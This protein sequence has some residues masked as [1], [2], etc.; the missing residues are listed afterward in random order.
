[1]SFLGENNLLPDSQFI[2]RKNRSTEDAI[3]LAINPWL[4]AKH[5]RRITGIV[6]VDMS[7]AFDRVRHNLLIS[8]LAAIGV[9]E[10]VRSWLCSYLSDRRQRV[11]VGDNHSDHARCSRGVPQGSVLGPLLFVIYISKRVQCL[12]AEVS[13]MEYADD[14]MLECTHLSPSTICRSLSTAVTGLGTWFEDRGL[15]PVG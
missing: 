6:F 13:N 5:Q 12:P 11:R 14:V 4:L 2:Y 10:L 7:K 15:A 3:T 1:M 8:D 9:H